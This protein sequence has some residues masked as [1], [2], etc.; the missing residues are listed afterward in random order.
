MHDSQYVTNSPTWGRSLAA[1]F[2]TSSTMKINK[3]LVTKS[4]GA[5]DAITSFRETK[6]LGHCLHV[7]SMYGHL[8]HM[9]WLLK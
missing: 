2:F 8:I 6:A 7:F 4:W 1:K 5:K 9:W 3:Y